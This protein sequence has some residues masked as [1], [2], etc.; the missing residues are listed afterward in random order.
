M[1]TIPDVYGEYYEAKGRPI[2][3]HSSLTEETSKLWQKMKDQA[4]ACMYQNGSWEDLDNSVKTL[5]AHP[6]CNWTESTLNY[7]LRQNYWK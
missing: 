2:P 1:D 5:A 3:R 7:W 4:H 6:D